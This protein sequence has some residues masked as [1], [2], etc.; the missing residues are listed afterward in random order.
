[1]TDEPLDTR[2]EITVP[3]EEEVGAFA[4]FASVWRARDSFVLDFATEVSPPEVAEDRATGERYVH[5]PAR[6]VARVRIP[7]GQ[8]W[9]LMRALEQ[10]L[11]AYERESGAGAHGE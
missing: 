6:V 2:V 9:D 3:P 5:V 8:V 4:G 1:M 10:N 7:P 11:S